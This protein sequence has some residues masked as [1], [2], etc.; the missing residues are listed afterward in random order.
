MSDNQY[1]KENMFK[2]AWGRVTGAFKMLPTV[3]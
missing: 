2:R 3:L 1:Y